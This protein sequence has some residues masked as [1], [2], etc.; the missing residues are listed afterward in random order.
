MS[1]VNAQQGSAG[2]N[3]GN[4]PSAEPLDLSRAKV[5]AYSHDNVFARI[6]A[7][8]EDPG[9]GNDQAEADLRQL[10]ADML[11]YQPPA[12]QGDVAQAEEPLTAV[13]SQFE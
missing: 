1:S 4:V 12:S 2:S 11:A 10:E 3:A 6:H 5:A 9:V 13:G 8:G 7:R